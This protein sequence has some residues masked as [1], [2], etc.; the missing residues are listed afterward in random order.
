LDGSQSTA[1]DNI[2]VLRN[3]DFSATD[4]LHVMPLCIIN[5][6]TLQTL[7]LQ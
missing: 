5:A 4:V 3:Y 2:N 6:L 1:A 7:F